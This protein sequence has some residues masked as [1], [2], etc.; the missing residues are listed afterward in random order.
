[1][2]TGLSTE[3]VASSCSGDFMLSIVSSNFLFLPLGDVKSILLIGWYSADYRN[4]GIIQLH[5]PSV[6]VLILVIL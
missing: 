3:A 1:M 2:S 4:V 6:G 5:G